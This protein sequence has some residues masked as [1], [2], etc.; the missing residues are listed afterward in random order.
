MATLMGCQVRWGGGSRGRGR[1]LEATFRLFLRDL[2]RLPLTPS[3]VR[4]GDSA[5]FD[6]TRS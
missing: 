6:F 4:A 1:W 5:H 3:T 2:G